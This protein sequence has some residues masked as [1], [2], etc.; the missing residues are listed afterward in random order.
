[1]KTGKYLALKIF[2]NIPNSQV[3]YY[4]NEMKEVVNHCKK[5]LADKSVFIQYKLCTED[6]DTGQLSILME[7]VPFTT[8]KECI[9]AY[10]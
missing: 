5:V 3:K 2:N 6:E 9:E 4:I 10:G 8:I 1:M 7:P